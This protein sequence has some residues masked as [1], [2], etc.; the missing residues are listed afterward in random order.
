MRFLDHP[1]ALVIEVCCCAIAEISMKH[2]GLF[3]IPGNAKKVAKLKAAFDAGEVDLT[4]FDKDPHSLAG[5]LKQYLRELPDPIMTHTLYNE[6]MH[7]MRLGN[8]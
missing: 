2:E 8:C 7:T 5:A 6:W 3:R 1:I 4:D